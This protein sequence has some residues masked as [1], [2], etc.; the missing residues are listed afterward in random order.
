MSSAPI[1]YLNIIAVLLVAPFVF[2][3]GPSHYGL[4]YMLQ[5]MKTSFGVDVCSTS[6]EIFTGKR[7][8]SS[9]KN[10]YVVLV[11]QYIH[12]R[13]VFKLNI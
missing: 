10:F 1:L 6:Q 13:T 2:P 9:R 4:S 12:Y 7:F 3:S 8:L 5:S 11:F